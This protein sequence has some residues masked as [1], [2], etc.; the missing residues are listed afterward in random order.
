M[1]LWIT[2]T[3]TCPDCGEEYERWNPTSGHK[4]KSDG[5]RYGSGYCRACSNER[6]KRWHRASSHQPQ[7]CANCGT[8]FTPTNIQVSRINAGRC[9]NFFCGKDC[10]K[11][12]HTVYTDPRCYA[13]CDP[14]CEKLRVRGIAY[15]QGHAKRTQRGRPIDTPL[16]VHAKAKP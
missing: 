9:R 3:R 10:R 2:P 6:V 4:R 7:P 5:A 1:T 12:F 8:R 16:K 13:P 14:P 15:C 11:E